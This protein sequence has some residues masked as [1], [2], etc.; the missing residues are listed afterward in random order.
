MRPVPSPT[1]VPVSAAG[2]VGETGTR[3]SG[4]QAGS[5]CP[6]ESIAGDFVVQPAQATD[7]PATVG[8]V[9]L[10]MPACCYKNSRRASK[11]SIV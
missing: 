9:D 4:E 10:F 5:C 6:F 3:R 1:L 2:L 8:V 7:D 11:C